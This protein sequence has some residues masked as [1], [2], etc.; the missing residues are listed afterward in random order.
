MSWIL[1]NSLKLGIAL[2]ILVGM[3]IVKPY[4]DHLFDIVFENITTHDLYLWHSNIE[5]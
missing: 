1:R 2:I 3:A 5:V 4:I